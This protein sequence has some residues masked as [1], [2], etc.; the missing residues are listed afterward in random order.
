MH[1]GAGIIHS[2]RPSQAMAERNGRSEVVQLWINSPASKKLVQPD[3][4]YIPDSDIPTFYSEDMQFK[5]KLI[6]GN[7]KEHTGLILAQSEL[8]VLWTRADKKATQVIT[9]PDG[10]NVMLYVVH[11]ELRISGFGK[12]IAESL[13]IFDQ[14]RG[15]IE[16]STDSGTQFIFLSGEPLGE[17]VVQQGPFVMNTTTEILEA[18][19]DYQ[20]GKMGVLIEEK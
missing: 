20:M 5:N 19:R 4:Q 13:V 10:F 7:Y 17:N 16:V 15:D 1:A 6:A 11:G 18:M 12:V 2:E 14:D 9:P 3:Y 8:L